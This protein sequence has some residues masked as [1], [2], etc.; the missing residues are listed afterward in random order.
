MTR[1]P[2]SLCLALPLCAG[3]LVTLPAQAIQHMTMGESGGGSGTPPKKAVVDK[4]KK[5]WEEQ[6]EVV[7]EEVRE[8][9]DKATDVATDKAA[10]QAKKTGKKVWEK[11]KKSKTLGKYAKKAEE[12]LRRYKRVLGPVGQVWDAAERGYT[13]GGKIHQHIVGPLMAA[14]FDRKEAE[15]QR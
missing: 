14:H 6:P 4:L 15:W 9:V 7:K 10:E 13:A 12:V 5:K 3:L 8:K 2:S 1:L 11:I